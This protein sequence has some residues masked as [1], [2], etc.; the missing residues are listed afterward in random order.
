[1][2]N[3]KLVRTLQIL[4]TEE[5][6]RLLQFLKSPFYNA[7]PS[8][9]K[10]YLLLRNHH[11]AFDSRKLTKESVF[12]KL[13][14]NREY[15][16]K[17]LLNLMT[18]F[19]ALLEKYL[20]LLQLEKEELEQK[21]LLIRAYAD[22]PDCYVV[23]EKKVWELDRELDALPYRDEGYF[24]EKKEVNLL[25]YGHP[26]TSKS[27]DKKDTLQTAVE[28]FNAYRSFA[29]IKLK[30]ASNAMA[31]TVSGKNI[32]PTTSGNLLTKNP[33]YVLY[34]KLETFQRKGKATDL[35]ELVDYFISNIELLRKEDQ[36]YIL[37]MLLNYCIRQ[38]NSG[39]LTFFN[40][41]FKLYQVGLEY[42]C[43]F[44][45]GKISEG[46]F[47]NIVTNA[48]TINELAWAK[49]FM[50]NYGAKLDPKIKEE[51]MTICLAQWHFAKKEYQK[52]IELLRYLFREPSVIFKSKALVI[53]ALFE[54]YWTDES[55]MDVLLAQL[56]A[57]EK[58]ARRSKVL[59]SR[60]TGAFIKF[61]IFTKKLTNAKGSKKSYDKLRIELEQEPN[62]VFKQWLLEKATQY[63]KR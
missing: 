11:P 42:Y 27:T 55:Y 40:T 4:N 54:L 29:E 31:N 36:E 19:R 47:Q 6:K 22:R 61:I 12:Q 24:R 44:V 9:V 28:H 26:D 2:K 15:D 3:S 51:A 32:R 17:K 43:L 49:K 34:E 53:K 23:F 7:N 33:A 62:V 13:F 50:D 57:F 16:H 58:Y 5:L 21:K 39:K 52:T 14:P 35:N 10:L 46:T 56:D 60:L 38:T 30:C 63:K 37:K 20:M 25:Y 45:N 1:M 18:D 48:I 8:I 41:S 59:T